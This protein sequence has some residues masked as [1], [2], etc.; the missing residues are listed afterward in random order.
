MDEIFLSIRI[1]KSLEERTSEWTVAGVKEWRHASLNRITKWAGLLA[2]M[3]VGAAR[4]AVPCR[5]INRSLHTCSDKE[6]NTD[7]LRTDQ[8][9]SHAHH[10]A[11]HTAKRL[12]YS[13]RG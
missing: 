5:V 8:T 10:G 2:R 13:E 12:S 1:P 6:Q 4:A 3:S 7:E 11:L 9:C